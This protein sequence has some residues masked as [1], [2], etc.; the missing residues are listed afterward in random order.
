MRLALIAAVAFAAASCARV[1]PPAQ[2]VD[3]E[4]LGLGP[5]A[6][7]VN[8]W[9]TWCEPCRR[10]MQ[11]LER[12]HRRL[13][14][15]GVRVIGISVDADRNLAREFLL[16]ERL[17]FPNVLDADTPL[18]RAATKYPTTYLLSADGV[19]LGK[20]ESALDWSSAESLARLESAFG[21]ALT[22]PPA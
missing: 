4:L 15:S 2:Q 8:V 10:E 1:E 14:G 16:R 18:A 19:V 6:A 21:R 11:S 9:A 7:I 22:A 3:V 5:G 20:I 17:T 13:E 12:L